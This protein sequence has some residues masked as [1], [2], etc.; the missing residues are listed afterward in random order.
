MR[1]LL[2]AL[3]LLTMPA[4]ADLVA[5]NS[6]K[7]ELRLMPGPCIHGGTLGLIAEEWRSRFKKA[8]ADIGGRLVFGCWIDTGEGWYWVI[9]ETGQG[10]A[11]PITSFLDQPGV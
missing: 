4:R 10:I 7:D 2:A 5:T 11:Y 3:V 6:A 1:Y 8:Q 9:F